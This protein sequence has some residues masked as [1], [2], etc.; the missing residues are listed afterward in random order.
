MTFVSFSIGSRKSVV[1]V[2]L[3]NTENLLREQAKAMAVYLS[4]EMADTVQVNPAGA[5]GVS[6]F[7]L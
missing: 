3:N 2:F 6:L 4:G 1:P 5:Y 7:S